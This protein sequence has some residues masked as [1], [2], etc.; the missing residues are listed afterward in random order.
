MVAADAFSLPSTDDE[1]AAGRVHFRA[2]VITIE[3][4]EWLWLAHG[5]HRR[6]EYVFAADGGVSARWLVP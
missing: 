1:I 5:G 3:T 6:A 2:V 4:L